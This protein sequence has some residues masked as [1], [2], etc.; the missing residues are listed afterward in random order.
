MNRISIKPAGNDFFIKQLT[1][2]GLKRVI[3]ILCAELII[4][5]IPF[6]L[7]GLEGNFNNNLLD[8]DALHDLG[9]Y[10][11]FFLLL[12]FFIVF[13]P[14]YL[15]GL[16][17]A[18]NMLIESEV[19]EINTEETIE[20]E[21]Y[22]KKIFGN[23]IIT[24]LP[25]LI[26]SLF[27]IFVASTF[28]FAGKNTWNSIS[29]IG[30]I[31]AIEIINILLIFSLYYLISGFFLRIILTSLIINKFLKNRV[32]VQ[33]LHPD[34][35][36]G[37]SPLGDFSLR[38]TKA[39]IVLGIPVLLGILTDTYQFGFSLF[40]FVNILLMGGYILCLSVVFFLPLLGARKSMLRAK[41][42]EL[43][44]ISDH[45][46]SE[47]KDILKR[48]KVGESHANLDISNL[49]GL[50]KLY[51]IAKGMPVY[52]FNSKNVV[53]FLSSVLWPLALLLL[54]FVIDRIK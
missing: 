9:W 28:I 41:T 27:S 42:K 37:L 54:Q 4:A 20:V 47:R 3:I 6:L 2:H 46:Q 53:R 43:K 5:L 33:P 21:D 31:S 48:Y 14:Y 35:C 19:V 15:N 51:E 32:N 38:L 23:W 12:P 24:F 30:N 39:G 52:P 1:D 18:L 7:S 25:C 8:V 17:V 10:N 45:F 49:E 11:Q 22:S 26:S 36:G 50:M 44:I 13:I 40:S 16:E 29:G 34:Y